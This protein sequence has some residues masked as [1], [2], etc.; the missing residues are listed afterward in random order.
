MQFIFDPNLG[1][2]YTNLLWYLFNNIGIHK[3][4][5]TK[6]WGLVNP[7]LS[8]NLKELKPQ[9]SIEMLGKSL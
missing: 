1:Q 9:C 3:I 2:S 6:A 4:G 7:G 5:F 8:E